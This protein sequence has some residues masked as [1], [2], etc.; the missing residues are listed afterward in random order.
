MTGIPLATLN[1]LQSIPN[2]ALWARLQ[3]EGRLRNLTT[4][5]TTGP[6]LNFEP[7][8]PE[9]EIVAEYLALWDHL[10]EPRNFYARAYRYILEMRP[11]R[12]ALGLAP[13]GSPRHGPAL[14]AAAA[15]H[16]RGY[17]AVLWRLFWRRAVFSRCN[18]LLWRLS[19]AVY[20]RNPS[21]L[22]RFFIICALGE[23]LFPL[24][25]LVRQGARASASSRRAG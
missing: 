21:R 16:R 18:R 2:T 15:G 9:A 8:R 19:L 25:A 4:G 13:P 6:R 17:V 24:R 7:S 22:K 12:R 1:I 23:N 20:R 5:D 11:T 3:R 14:R 10:Y